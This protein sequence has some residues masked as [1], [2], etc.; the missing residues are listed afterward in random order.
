MYQNVIV[1]FWINLINSWIRLFILTV[2]EGAL[3]H[4]LLTIFVTEKLSA[5]MKFY[6]EKKDFVE[7]LGNSVIFLIGSLPKKK[8][9][10]LLFRYQLTSNFELIQDWNT[11]RMFVKCESWRSCSWQRTPQN[12]ASIRCKL[13]CNW[14]K[15]RWKSS[16]LWS[17]RQSWCEPVWINSTRRSWCLPPCTGLSANSTGNNCVSC[18]PRGGLSCVKWKIPCR[19][20]STN[21]QNFCPNNLE[22][23]DIA[24]IPFMKIV[25]TVYTLHEWRH[26]RF[27]LLF[28]NPNI[29]SFTSRKNFFMVKRILRIWSKSPSMKLI[30]QAEIPISGDLFKF[31][32]NIN[33]QQVIRCYLLSIFRFCSFRT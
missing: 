19:L 6:E 26:S 16:S 23:N 3:L 31:M 13:S 10:I 27:I 7:G 22:K 2:L 14:R 9:T 28:P 12:S 5:Y 30:I 1:N 24:I 18:W 11:N 29:Q 8:K 17:S 32:K 33:R 20:L 4:D 21:R 25:A 15:P